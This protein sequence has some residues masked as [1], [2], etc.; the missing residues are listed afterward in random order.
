MNQFEFALDLLERVE[1]TAGRDDMERDPVLLLS[2]DA[3][4][5]AD[6]ESGSCENL[7]EMKEAFRRSHPFL[8]SMRSTHFTQALPSVTTPG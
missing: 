2:A 4:G 5:A 8:T 6:E 1:E 7:K 3:S